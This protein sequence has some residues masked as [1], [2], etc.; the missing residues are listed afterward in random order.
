MTSD[1]Q[2]STGWQWMLVGEFV[3]F[4]ARISVLED[5]E[6]GSLEACDVF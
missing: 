1:V 4:W 3:S 2:G 5:L 6:E